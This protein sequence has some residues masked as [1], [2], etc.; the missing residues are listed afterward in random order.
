MQSLLISG[1]NGNM[2]KQIYQKVLGSRY[3][4]VCGVD[5]TLG[6]NFDCPIYKDFTQ[7][8]ETVDYIVD[9]SSNTLFDSA[10][11]FAVENNCAF[12]SGTTNLT[13]TQVQK[14][15]D[16]SKQI[17]VFLSSN[18]ALC[19]HLF[20]TCAC[21]IAKAFDW[22]SVYIIET[23]HKNKKDM[24]SGTAI[25]LKNA[26]DKTGKID[27]QIFSQRGGNVIGEHQVTFLGDDQT[28]TITHNAQSRSIFVNGVM[29]ALDFIF[30]KKYGFFTTSDLE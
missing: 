30:N 17:P 29:L 6:G 3:N 19:V 2:G 26:I 9:F 23:H 10:L 1:I 18:T 21:N 16:A 15:K 8:K 14:A 13:Q 5:K 28:I 11:L 25:D 4:V 22:Q 20:K 27:A 24:P 7:V 12:I